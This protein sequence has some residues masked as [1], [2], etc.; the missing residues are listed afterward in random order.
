MMKS[1]K[2]NNQSG[3]VLLIVLVLLT[4]FD[5]IGVTFVYYAASADCEQNPTVEVRDGRCVQNIGPD[6][7]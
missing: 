5:V 2:N 4:V 6:T 3:V 1:A 7:R